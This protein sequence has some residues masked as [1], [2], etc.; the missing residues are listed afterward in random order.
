MCKAQGSRPKDHRA[1]LCDLIK[2]LPSWSKTLLPLVFSQFFPLFRIPCFTSSL[3]H[4][5][6]I[7]ILIVPPGLG[8][9]THIVSRLPALTYVL[10]PSCYSSRAPGSYGIYKSTSSIFSCTCLSLKNPAAPNSLLLNAQP[11]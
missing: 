10:I 7:V 3:L 11:T 4:L 2:H 9:N 8:T 5:L 6:T 1:C